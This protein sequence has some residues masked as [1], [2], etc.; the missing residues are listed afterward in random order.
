MKIIATLL[1]SGIISANLPAQ[2]AK[3]ILD[4][5][6]ANLSSSSRIIEAAM[7]VRG[8]R[9]SRTITFRSWSEGVKR[10]FTEYLSPAAERGT[11]MLKLEG[12]L[13]IYSPAADR[14]IQI[15]GHLLRQSVMG[16]DLSYEDLMDDRRLADLYDARLEGEDSLDGRRMLLLALTDR[17]GEAAYHSQRMWVDD[18]RYVPLRQELYAKGGKLLKRI[19]LGNVVRIQGR[20][21]PTIMVFKDMLKQGEGTEFKITDMVVGQKI[22]EHIFSKA[23]LKR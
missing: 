2:S 4:R 9:N 7:T 8:R 6:D 15:S 18:E 22:P 12:R 5:V 17:T 13:W 3:D 20:W 23:A 21:Y 11:K 19:D 1:L 10:S 14:I 16:S